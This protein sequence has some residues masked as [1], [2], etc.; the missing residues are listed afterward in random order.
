M[1]IAYISYEFPP[2]TSGG[3]IGSYTEQI[4]LLMALAGHSVSVFC[5][6][7]QPDYNYLYRG[8]NVYR[9]QAHDVETFRRKV[10]P[11]F[12]EVQQQ[13]QF[14]IIEGPDYGADA[15]FIKT[16][17]PHLPYIVKLHTPA[18]IIKEYNNYYLQYVLPGN[19]Y[20]MLRSRLKCI[21]GN[22]FDRSSDIEY[23][24]LLLADKVHSPSR[25]LAK[26]ISTDWGVPFRKITIVPNPYNPNAALLGIPLK[27]E[28]KRVIFIGK[29]SLLK[30]ALDF[31][32]IIQGVLKNMPDLMFL[33][34]GDDSFSPHDG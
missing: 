33:F 29:L 25:A 16:A 26:R 17:F 22:A 11:F 31:I 3:G 12:A 28:H 7:S 27:Y 9:I 13:N 34:V 6:T 15:Y 5:G 32:N 18:Y 14:S 10:V 19:I 4:S 23:Q 30:G 2:D 24:N 21:K 1:R 8:V 20:Q